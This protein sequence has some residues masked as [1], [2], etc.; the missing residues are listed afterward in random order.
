MRVLVTGAGAGIGR[1][2]AEAFND[3]EAEVHVCDVDG[4]ALHDLTQS[5][6]SISTT[7]ANVSSS[8][9]TDRVF[10]DFASRSKRIDVLVNNAGISGP[11]APLEET[12]EEE[13]RSCIDVNLT[14]SFLYMRRAIP[15]MKRQGAGA[16]INISTS[17]AK[18]GLPMRSAYV[19]SKAGLVAFTE[20]AAREL[21]PFGIRCNAVLPGIIDN[22]RGRALIQKYAAD[23][24]LDQDAAEQEFLS[25]VSMRTMIKPPEV[26]EV[27]L[28]LASEQARHITGQAIGV[29]GN[30]EWEA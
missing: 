26:A 6:P 23:R 5:R 30:M 4:D 16:I 27:C 18:T 22:P 21:G 10:E 8:E 13:W 2:I 28:F 20:N 14:A 17:S 7:V 15:W 12:D 24:G 29:D 3:A 9:D 1:A 11:R 25:F 19:A